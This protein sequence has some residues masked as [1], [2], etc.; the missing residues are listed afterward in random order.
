MVDFRSTGQPSDSQRTHARTHARTHPQS[1]TR[2]FVLA[3]L[4]PPT[5]KTYQTKAKAV[6][7]AATVQ[8][9]N[10]S[11]APKKILMLG[12]TR[13]IGVY[14]AR[15]LV[16]QGHDVTLLTRGKSPVV[17]QIPD[18]T[19]ESFAAYSSRINHIAC[20]RKDAEAMKTALS[21]KGFQVVYDMN[22]REA[23]EAA[24]VLD[25]MPDLEQYI[26]C[27]SAGVY[28]K[29]D[30]MPHREEDEVDYASRHK[31][32][33]NTETLL[34]D[35]GVTFTSIRPVY[36]YGPLNYNPVEEMVFHRLK[37]GRPV[38]VP[39][40]GQQVTQLGHVKDL[41]VAFCKALA[42]PKAYNQ[43]YNIS[44]ERFVTFNGFVKAC[45]EAGGFPE[46]EIVNFDPKS[47]DLGKAKAFP[48][49]DQHFFTSI[50]KAM[51]DL[52]WAPEFGLV[53]GL[54]DSFEKD[55]GRGSFRKAA[56][57]SADDIILAA[58]E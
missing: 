1:A 9:V 3:P 35:R 32:K 25:A 8:T 49:R 47:V 54:R 43:I 57:F 14:V 45:A 31:G 40:S 41:A 36:I 12:G 6:G 19:D 46:P 10:A 13:F 30:M 18:D 53:E 7:R 2:G 15:M 42:N 16:E 17:S 51:A 55:F 44:G 39:G 22:G 5:T 34:R 58:A 37:E 20:D 38:M 48:F 26:F 28:M 24:I 52:D 50:D 56:D 23:D 11:V 4:G 27:S 21:G 33:L 29:S